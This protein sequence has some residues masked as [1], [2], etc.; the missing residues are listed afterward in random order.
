VA[1][2]LGVA[3][4]LLLLC[5]Y[6]YVWI[7][8]HTYLCG[9]VCECICFKR[10]CCFLVLSSTLIRHRAPIP[11]DAC[12]CVLVCVYLFSYLDVCVLIHSSLQ[13]VL[14]EYGFC[15]FFVYALVY[16]VCCIHVYVFI[17]DVQ[18]CCA[19]MCA[20]QGKGVCR[21]G[22]QPCTQHLLA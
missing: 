22:S 7:Y 15:Y 16:M 2:R 20:C 6:L 13:C 9:Y 19:C 3:R 14:R 12:A 21:E 17:R 11:A 8:S 18:V 4:P 5:A 1:H 10:A